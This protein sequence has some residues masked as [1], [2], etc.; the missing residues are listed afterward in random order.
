[1]LTCQ[2]TQL[3]VSSVV[4]G[5]RAPEL[6]DSDKA[7]G[8]LKAAA[9]FPADKGG[10]R[11]DVSLMSRSG[12][13]GELMRSHRH[14]LIKKNGFLFRNDKL[15]LTFLCILQLLPQMLLNTANP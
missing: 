13:P 6:A 1:M 2:A 8:H 11:A 15:M 12:A 9:N 4:L 3:N 14:R 7:T 10:E 5:L